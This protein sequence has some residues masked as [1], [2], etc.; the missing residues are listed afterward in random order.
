LANGGN[1]ASTSGQ[2]SD[3]VAYWRAVISD[4]D[5]AVTRYSPDLTCKWCNAAYAGLL[6]RQPE[7]V[8]GRNL[9][10]FLDPGRAELV[11]NRAAEALRFGAVQPIEGAWVLPDGSSRWLSWHV[12]V[13]KS[14]VT[15]A[16]E[17]QSV[18]RDIQALKDREAELRTAMDRVSRQA[19]D[20]ALLL[21]ELKAAKIEADSANAAK[22]RFL[23]SMSHELRTPLNAIIGFADI[24][25]L[26]L[27]GP[28]GS[29][30]YQDYVGDIWQSGKHLLDVISGLL[31]LSRIETGLRHMQP[32]E[33]DPVVLAKDTLALMPPRADAAVDL[34]V[35][36]TADCGRFVAD[37]L[38]VRQATVNLLY[39][40]LK[41]TAA[42][43]DRSGRV[44][45]AFH[46]LP[47][48]VEI[49]VG[50]TG[51]GL[52]PQQIE[53]LLSANGAIDDDRLVARKGRGAGLG[54]AIA[55]SLAE[56]HG[57]SLRF[58]SAPGLGTKAF[59]CIPQPPV[60][61]SAQPEAQS[62]RA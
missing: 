13:V 17:L 30:V 32:A 1:G 33:I 60:L 47:G 40:A 19:A 18:G 51:P 46:R 44:W 42:D 6:G 28:I 53:G 48:R 54:V 15:G 57:G 22:S 35:H 59:L 27:L 9:A 7:E 45:L 39:N 55:K 29:E 31:D 11:R 23:A 12:R 56:A 50:D 38:A 61:V 43:G 8:I 58:E 52:T 3:Q 24:M 37:Q 41:F 4:L 20:T 16:A 2:T 10:E 5:D 14:P 49:E 34:A 26:G 36:G 25:R 21:G 62:I